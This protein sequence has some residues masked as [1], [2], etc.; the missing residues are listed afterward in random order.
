MTTR[1]PFAIALLMCS[2][3]VSTSAASASTSLLTG[4]PDLGGPT[5]AARVFANCTA[6]NK[7]YK[8]GV[9]RKG[10]KDRVSG[11]AKPVT[12][13][14]VNTAVYSANKSRDRDKDGVA[15]EKR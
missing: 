15:C 6:L 4:P 7:T 3:G 5:I 11:T 9:G 8:H 14:T 12:N 1:R 2:L 10:A 13:F